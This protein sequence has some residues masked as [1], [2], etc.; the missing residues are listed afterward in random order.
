MTRLLDIPHEP[1][2]PR[3]PPFDGGRGY[4]EIEDELPEHYAVRPVRPVAQ[5][6]AR[7]GL[8]GAVGFGCLGGLIGL[9]RPTAAA[10]VPAVVAPVEEA[11]V[12]S[13]VSG[14]AE[15]TV[16]AWLT[17]TEN[18]REALDALFVDGVSVADRGGAALTVADVSTVAGRRL[19]AGYWTVTVAADVTE[20]P[21]GGAVDPA[22]GAAEPVTATWYVEVGIVGDVGAGLAALTTPAVMPA[23]PGVDDGWKRRDDDTW[24]PRDDDPIVGAVQGF[25]SALLTGEGD[26]LRYMATGGSITAADPPPF[27][28][29]VVLQMAV[30]G[31]RDDTEVRAWTQAEATT[32]GGS[33]R[34]VAYE[35][36][37]TRSVD[38]WE[39][40]EL[41]GVPL[42]VVA[43][44]GDDAAEGTDP[45]DATDATDGTSGAD[46]SEGSNDSGEPAPNGGG[47]EGTDSN[48]P[49]GSLPPAVDSEPSDPG[50]GGTT[51][52]QGDGTVADDL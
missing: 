52:G 42:A 5:L 10:D 26:P 15:R 17:A 41:S 40:T 31:D 48:G 25:L 47:S 21:A 13:P 7:V 34:V 27:T 8:W 14:V 35:L 43:P 37:L 24:T 18:D 51:D 16:E 23:P 12:P 4:I 49:G 30:T 36:V 28:E 1:D 45:A 46:D 50:G 3:H 39:I 6:A 19:E 29:V 38:R 32:G 2:A 33:R 44:R 22:G 11:G 20:P 9:I